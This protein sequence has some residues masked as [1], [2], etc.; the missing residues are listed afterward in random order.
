MR[1][2]NDHS[3]QGTKR[4]RQ[5][6]AVNPYHVL[7]VR[8][9][10]TPSELREAYRRLA[11]WHHPGRCNDKTEQVRRFQIFRNV[12]ACYET[13]QDNDH[14]Q[15]YD[16]LVYQLER[17]FMLGGEILVGGK[18][19]LSVPWTSTRKQ[20]NDTTCSSPQDDSD[21]GL[22]GLLSSSSSST[23]G[24]D[25]IHYSAEETNRLY[26]GPLHLLYK[27]RRYQPFT[28]PYSVFENVFGSAIF[29]KIEVT[30]DKQ[31]AHFDSTKS[32]KQWTG[33]T[34]NLANGTIVTTTSRVLYNRKLT[35]T[36]VSV[37]DTLNGKRHSTIQVK[38]ESWNDSIGDTD[39][40]LWL[41]VPPSWSDY[42]L[43][44]CGASTND[45]ND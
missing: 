29:D 34:K 4:P 40:N 8:R 13:L 18:P 35:R 31:Y 36:E 41:C 12:A 17:N 14:R 44:S 37:T 6:D 42:I 21:E 2:G 10:A 11:L 27:A 19:L 43:S 38:A 22:P 23:T 24:D 30:D 7:Q 32:T 5:Q 15:R 20:Q 45:V 3:T 39:E 9:D 25:E 1:N 28:D 33:S 26:G 16:V